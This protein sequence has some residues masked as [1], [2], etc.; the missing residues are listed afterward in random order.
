VCLLTTSLTR[1]GGAI[2]FDGRVVAPRAV[3][4]RAVKPMNTSAPDRAAIRLIMI[5][6]VVE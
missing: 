3:S 1:F 6:L 4:C 2:G 5:V